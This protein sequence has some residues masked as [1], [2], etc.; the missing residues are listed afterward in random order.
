MSKDVLVLFGALGAFVGIF[1]ALL[2]I[3]LLLPRRYD[4][5]LVLIGG[6]IIGGGIGTAVVAVLIL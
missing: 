2:M 1:L 5:I 4:D 6:I 3:E